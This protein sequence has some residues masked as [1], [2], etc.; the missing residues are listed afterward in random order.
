LFARRVAT[1]R[2]QFPYVE[3]R[4]RR[5]D[6][7]AVAQATVR[8][9]VDAAGQRCPDLPLIAG[10]KS[11][12]G[13]MTAQAQAAS[14]LPHVSGLAFFGFPLHATG[15]PSIERAAHL[16]KVMIPMLFLQG[17]KDKLA[18]PA[19]I[20][21]VADGLDDRATLHIINDA[22]HSFHVPA[23]SGRTDQDVIDE[24]ATILAHWLTSAPVDGL[25]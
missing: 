7:P 21:T 11:F 23:R 14:P 17:S 3:A 1:L 15:N 8:A 22:D 18:D 5:P 12:G 2:Y 25:T 13:R 19:L 16:S 24:T 9:A 10:G 4:S 20:A 6:P